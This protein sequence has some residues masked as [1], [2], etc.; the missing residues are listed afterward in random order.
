LRKQEIGLEL[1]GIV[2]TARARPRDADASLLDEGF[3]RDTKGEQSL[4]S[5][6]SLKMFREPPS[7]REKLGISLIGIADASSCKRPDEVEA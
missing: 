2:I 6:V 5:N 3:T 7:L 1:V 4:A